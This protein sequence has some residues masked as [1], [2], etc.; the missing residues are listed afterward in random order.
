MGP[1]LELRCELKVEFARKLQYAGITRRGNLPRAAGI[2][3]RERR[4]GSRRREAIVD[5]CP[6]RVVEDVVGLEP[7]LDACVF[8]KVE[9]LK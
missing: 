3:A 9:I 8:R 5:V 7:Q 6:L 1:A 2:R 4:A